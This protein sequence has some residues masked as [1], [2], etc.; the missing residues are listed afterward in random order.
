MTVLENTSPGPIVTIA[1]GS[2]VSLDGITLSGAT[3]AGTSGPYGNGIECPNAVAGARTVHVARSVV[4]NNANDGIQGRTCTIS[5]SDSSFLNNGRFGIE[6]ADATATIDRCVVSGNTFAAASFDA[7][8]YTVTNSFVVRNG[9]GI[10]FF[11][12][13]TGSRF[14]FNTI[15]DNGAK[16]AG[17]DC[18]P[19]NTAAQMPNNII[20]RNAP[21]TTSTT[22]SFPGSIIATDVSALH[23]KSPDVAPYDYHL[24]GGSMAIDLGIASTVDHDFDGDKRPQGPA[25]DVGADEAQ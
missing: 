11:S 13:T 24:G 8:L 20:A 23:F 21:N 17:L 2:D 4:T 19:S 15:V 22:C 14:E 25:N 16:I 7:G 5:A 12:Q 3:S 6:L 10:D 1:P 9:G 18:N